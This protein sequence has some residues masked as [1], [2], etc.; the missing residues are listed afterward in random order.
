MA[1]RDG[2]RGRDGESIA[3]TGRLA[4]DDSADR[5]NVMGVG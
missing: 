1:H 3:E 4:H 5:Q 2:R